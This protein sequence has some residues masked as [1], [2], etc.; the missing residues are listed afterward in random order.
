MSFFSARRPKFLT[1]DGNFVIE[2]A[3][4]RNITFRLLGRSCVKINDINVMNLI[5]PTGNSSLP[6]NTAMRLNRLETRMNSMNVGTP[7]RG[8]LNRLTRLEN[9][10]RNITGDVR[11]AGINRRLR[12]LENR[13]NTLMNSLNSDNCT[14]NPC[15]NGATCMNAINGYL[16]KCPDAWTGDS[17]EQDVNECAI[18]AGTDLGCQN[19]ATCTNTIGSYT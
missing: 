7:N 1:E 3:V 12:A 10:V 15:K 16:C 19:G 18:F 13:L 6:P 2:S 4:D 9:R 17:C 14:S 8:V 11:L 5:R